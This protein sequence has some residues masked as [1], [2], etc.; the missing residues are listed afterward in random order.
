MAYN[1]YVC[2]HGARLTERGCEYVCMLASVINCYHRP[3]VP[4]ATDQDISVCPLG[5]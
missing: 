3:I 5:M 2:A 4:R 1:L